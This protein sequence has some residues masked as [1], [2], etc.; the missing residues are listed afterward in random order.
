[1]WR[2]KENKICTR[3][4]EIKPKLY[5]KYDVDDGV[6]SLQIILFSFYIKRCCC[7][8]TIS[9][10]SRDYNFKIYVHFK[11]IKTTII[12]LRNILREFLLF[13]GVFVNVCV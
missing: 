5:I 4:K 2:G 13:Y 1:M 3:G 12:K 8:F 6:E 9:L 10:D 11:E 7:C